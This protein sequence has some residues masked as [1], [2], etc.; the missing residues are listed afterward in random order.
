MIGAAGFAWDIITPPLI[1][2]AIVSA[3]SILAAMAKPVGAVIYRV[4]DT[5]NDRLGIFIAWATLIMVVV[6]F[7]LVLMRYIF[8]AKDFAGIST[9]W[10]QEAIVYSHGALIMLAAGYTFLHNG[11]VRVDI[12]Y[13]GAS[14]TKKDITDLLGSLLFLL[15]V[16]YI[17]WWSS[18]T[19][20][21]N[22]WPE[23]FIVFGDSI[24][25]GSSLADYAVSA[26]RAD[27]RAGGEILTQA[28]PLAEEIA[29]I[30]AA[31]EAEGRTFRLSSAIREIGNTKPGL[32]LENPALAEAAR[33]AALEKVEAQSWGL[34][35]IRGIGGE[36]STESSGIPAKWLLKTTI[37]VLAI[38]LALQALST[39]VKAAMRLA[40]HEVDDPYRNEESLD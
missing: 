19:N 26:A 34:G 35:P 28:G 1:I 4:C 10:W 13:R 33:A 20:V 22:S 29:R 25:Y 2:I 17:I 11:H 21:E 32:F 23:V 12:F 37:L 31:T 7:T 27:A 5:I 15:P 30:Q 3:I 40:G 14:E 24:W 16:C 8:A 6:Q 18:I 36:G 39:C 9:L 38:V